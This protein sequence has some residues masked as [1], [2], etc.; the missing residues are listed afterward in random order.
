MSDRLLTTRQVAELLGLSPATVLRRW[1]DGTLPGYRLASNVLRF[2]P[3]DIEDYLTA[4]RRDGRSEEPARE[5][6]RARP[7][8]VVSHLPGNPTT[9]GGTDAC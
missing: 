7:G 3:S 9:Q 4:C 6:R 2:D 5:P 1:R 8:A